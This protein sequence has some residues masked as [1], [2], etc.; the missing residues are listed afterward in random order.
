MK[1]RMST[2]PG[3]RVGAA[4][5][6]LV[7]GLFSAG[8]QAQGQAA[9]SPRA[10]TVEDLPAG[11]GQ[12]ETFFACTACHGLALVKAQGMDRRQWNDSVQF[13]IDR[14]KMAELPADDRELIVDYL[15]RHYP[16]RAPQSRGWQNPFSGQ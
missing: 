8:A 12:E 16:P 10:E 2:R 13:M 14:H 1:D 6:V 4:C 3:R 7:L 11:K 5:A 9:F 15:A